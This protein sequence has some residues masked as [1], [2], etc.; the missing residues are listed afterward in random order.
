MNRTQKLVLAGLLTGLAIVIPMFMPR[1]VLGAY[2]AT[3]ASH[4]PIAIATLLSPVMAVAVALGSAVGFFMT[5]PLVVALRALTHVLYAL[6]LALLLRRIGER[7]PLALI[8]AVL[9]TGVVHAAAELLVVILMGTGVENSQLIL[10]W[11]FF[12]T[13]AHHC[14]DF[15]LA[16]IVCRALKKARLWPK[17]ELV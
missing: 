14:V 9:I 2:T 11:T 15:G 12:G 13:L 4:L 6:L 5:A 3:L 1:F 16:F 8:F 10:F 17:S 7:R